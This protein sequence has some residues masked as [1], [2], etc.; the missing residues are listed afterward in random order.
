MT[1]ADR[2]SHHELCFGCGQANVFGL[3]LELE[4]TSQEEASGRFFVKQDHQGVPGCAH[5][6]VIA[7][8]LGEAM[9]L[10][11]QELQ[12][13]LHPTRLDLEVLGTARIGTFVT[14]KAWLE[15]RAEGALDMAAAAFG[16]G[17][18]RLP[19][20]ARARG[21][22]VGEAA[23]QMPPQGRAGTG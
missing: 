16:D 3:Q 22:F 17:E 8:A 1:R 5:E 6:G 19:A 7:A 2:L 4:P 20:L 11:A 9:S 21:R 15:G 14:L 23:V 18:Q 13:G 12:P 10:L